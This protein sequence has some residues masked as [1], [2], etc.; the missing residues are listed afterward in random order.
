MKNLV[1]V[2]GGTAGWLTAL[3]AQMMFPKENIVLVESKDLGILG[4]GEGS[5][6][7]LIFLLDF[8]DIPLSKVIK[9]TNATI[10][11]GVK[12]TNWSSKND[13]YYSGLFSDIFSN[14]GWDSS[15]LNHL[16]GGYNLFES[17]SAS[18]FISFLNEKKLIDYD[19]V[20]K[21]SDKNKIPLRFN[22][23]FRNLDPIHSFDRM[24]NI[25]LH[26][27]A[28]MLAKLLFDVGQ[29]RGI[30]RIEG[31]LTNIIANNNGEITNIHIDTGDNLEVDF[32]FDCTGFHRAIIGKFY[33]SEWISAAKHL[34]MK[35]ALPFF[36]ENKDEK[37][38]KPYSEAIAMDYG[39][40]WRIPLQHRVGSGYVFD[41]DRI[42]IDDAKIEVEKF[43]GQEVFPP[44]IFSFDPGYFKTI[45]VKNC[46]AVGLS[47]AFMEPMEAT[48]IW[49]AIG[50]LQIFFTQR[51]LIFNRNQ[52]YINMFNKRFEKDIHDV[53]DFIYFHYVTDKTNNSFWINFTK[54]NEMPSGLE[55]KLFLLQEGVL[56]PYYCQN[57][58]GAD[59]YYAVAKGNNILNIQNIKEIYNHNHLFE[60]NS[61]NKNKNYMK[62]QVAQTMIDHYEFLQYMKGINK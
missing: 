32:I 15:D 30:K 5:T 25:S 19:F 40:M 3:Y 42:S 34:P 44:K 8:L 20:A 28:R 57:M 35:K 11:N 59:N 47:S 60:L 43:L 12:F 37:N 27:D 54:E 61:L 58:F 52:K 10:K 39:W 23:Q 49:Q 29:E 33:K 21:I 17:P 46:L 4:A 26:F 62:E 50:E 2:G 16:V 38:I 18:N 45:W 56:V 31:N 7:N 9:E 53:I 41:S 51:Q 1:I 14:L 13:Y 6:P 24:A 36:L 22:Q 55:E 48:S